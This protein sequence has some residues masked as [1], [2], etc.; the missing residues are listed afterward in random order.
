MQA[1]RFIGSA[2]VLAG[3]VAGCGGAGADMQ[4]ESTLESR[5]DALPTCG[6]RSYARIFYSEPEMINEVGRWYCEC[7]SD[8]VYMYGRATAYFEFTDVSQCF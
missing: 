4:E 2:L 6:G 7:T 5:E 8:Y 3:L 1:K